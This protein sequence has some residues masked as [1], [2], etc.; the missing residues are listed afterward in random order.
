MHYVHLDAVVLWSYMT[1]CPHE[2]VAQYMY[3]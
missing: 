2:Q 3:I 1:I